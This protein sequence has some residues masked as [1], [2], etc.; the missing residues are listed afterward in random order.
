M[1]PIAATAW[2]AMAT[3]TA[4]TRIVIACD[5]TRRRDGSVDRLIG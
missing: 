3:V 4:V 5:R 1:A 2:V